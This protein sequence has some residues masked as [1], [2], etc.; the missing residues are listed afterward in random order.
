MKVFSDY[1]TGSKAQ[2]IIGNFMKDI[3][4]RSLFIPDAH[5]QADQVSAFFG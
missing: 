1:M 2:S 3:F 4:G 5:I